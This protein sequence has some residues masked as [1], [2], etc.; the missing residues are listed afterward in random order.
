[1][2]HLR[3]FSIPSRRAREHN[4]PQRPEGKRVIRI[5]LQ[6]RSVRVR[7]HDHL[8]RPA[9]NHASVHFWL[10]VFSPKEL[11]VPTSIPLCTQLQ[12]LQHPRYGRGHARLRPLCVRWRHL[13]SCVRY[14]VE[15][16]TI[17]R[18]IMPFQPI[19]LNPGATVP[20]VAAAWRRRRRLATRSESRLHSNRL[21]HSLH[22]RTAT[23][24]GRGIHCH[25]EDRRAGSG[26]R[27]KQ[28]KPSIEFK[29]ETHANIQRFLV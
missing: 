20:Q 23:G 13:R 8:H 19:D 22:R 7:D 9:A 4:R 2:H 6:R 26:V 17:K 25:G 28:T 3:C 11:R 5:P 18:Y 15:R 12:R 1:M 14:A 27:R 24:F 16:N 21:W 10:E 29:T